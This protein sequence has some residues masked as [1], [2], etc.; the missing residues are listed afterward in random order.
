MEELKRI[1]IDAIENRE[2]YYGGCWF[3]DI[4]DQKSKN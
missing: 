3:L 2:P 1:F 4:H